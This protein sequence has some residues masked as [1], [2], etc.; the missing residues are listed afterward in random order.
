M[1]V[2]KKHDCAAIRR[3]SRAGHASVLGC[4]DAPTRPVPRVDQRQRD[5]TASGH[6][7]VAVGFDVDLNATVVDIRLGE[8]G[9]RRHSRALSLQEPAPIGAQT[10]E[11]TIRMPW[12]IEKGLDQLRR[13]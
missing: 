12:G 8:I 9:N 11:V 1:P 7:P 2:S 10:P 13:R 4:G 6:R 3:P 5:I